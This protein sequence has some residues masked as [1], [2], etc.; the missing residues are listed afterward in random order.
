MCDCC[1]G[2]VSK[3]FTTCKKCSANI[4]TETNIIIIRE[5]HP[6]LVWSEVPESSSKNITFTCKIHN[7]EIISSLT[8]LKHV[9]NICPDCISRVYTLEEIK[10]RM[11]AQLILLNDKDEYK[12]HEMIKVKCN[13]HG[14]T[15]KKVDLVCTGAGC[16]QCAM[17]K[18]SIKNSISIEEF[19]LTS[20]TK[21][22]SKFKYI[23]DKDIFYKEKKL[24]VICPLHGEQIQGVKNHLYNKFG[25]NSCFKE[26]I[27]FSHHDESKYK[28][29]KTVLYY[30]RINYN[31]KNYYKIGITLK[32]VSYRF[33]Y[34]KNL[35]FKILIEEPFDDGSI[36]YRIEQ[37]IK[38]K[39]YNKKYILHEN[40]KILKDGGNHEIYNTNILL[41]VVEIINKHKGMNNE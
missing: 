21:Y 32:D 36:A 8:R 2:T 31:K 26:Q 27:L 41:S 23:I 37:E 33:K 13:Q 11:N 34:E 38:N 35:D 30:I 40:I 28:D 10:N 19:I 24:T 4:R 22:N 12:Y 1:S 17:E 3:L 25:C 5:K 9:K 15:E 39:F 29:R 20:N 16:K 14:I 7:K 18:L 6:N